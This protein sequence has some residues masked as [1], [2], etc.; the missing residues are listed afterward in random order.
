MLRFAVNGLVLAGRWAGL[1]KLMDLLAE[2]LPE[3]EEGARGIFFGRLFGILFGSLI[4]PN[5]A[6]RALGRG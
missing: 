6:G 4:H 1:Q 2:P 3:G 5:A